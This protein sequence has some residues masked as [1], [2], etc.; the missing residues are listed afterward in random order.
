MIRALLF[1]VLV[2]LFYMKTC[3]FRGA[4][5]RSPTEG[6]FCNTQEPEARYRMVPCGNL[7]C[8]CCHLPSRSNVVDFHA[9]SAQ[10]QFVNGYTTYLN[11]P[12][13]C[14]VCVCLSLSKY[15]EGATHSL[16]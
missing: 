13:V 1:F 2:D 7:S 9:S 8:S 4:I 6:L 15:R 3:S 10:H 12:A 14:C 16:S 11:C 5:P